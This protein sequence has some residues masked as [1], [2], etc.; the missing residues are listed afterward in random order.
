MNQKKIKIICGAIIVEGNSFVVVQE[1]K[2]QDKG[3]WS[4]PGGHLGNHESLFDGAIREVKEETGLDVVL[5]GLVGIYQNKINGYNIIRIIFK[6][7]KRSGTFKFDETE[8][9]NVKWVSFDD[10]LSYPSSL[11]RGKQIMTMI[12]N[13]RSRGV[14]PVDFINSIQL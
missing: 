8:I 1:G 6:A 11:V 7:T 9:L 3:K 4:I 14:I 2:K 12:R 13:F 5:D 10:F